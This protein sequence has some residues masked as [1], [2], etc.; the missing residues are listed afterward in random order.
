MHGSV[1]TND[2]YAKFANENTVEVMAM[3]RLDEAIEKGERRA[4]TYA[5]MREGREVRFMFEWPGLTAEEM[6]ALNR[7]KAGTYN[8]TGGIPMTFLVDPHTLAEIT[9]WRGGGTTAKDI[10][11]GVEAARKTLAQAHGQGFSRKAWNKILE[12]EEDAWARVGKEDY[13]KAVAALDKEIAKGA[14]WPE[15]VKERLQGTRARVVAVAEARIQELETLAA[16]DAT[17][18]K[19]EL[20]KLLRKLK[21]TGLESRVEAFLQTLA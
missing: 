4:S 13:T 9:R 14:G 7:S 11:E 15:E 6:N 18:A 20:R 10:V 17:K 3:G 5:G 21:G 2:K 16:E 1:L 19:A 8:D 12:A